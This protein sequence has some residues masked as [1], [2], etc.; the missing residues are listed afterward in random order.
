MLFEDDKE[1]FIL[2]KTVSKYIILYD[3]NSCVF[4]YPHEQEYLV[5]KIKDKE[6]YFEFDGTHIIEDNNDNIMK[7]LTQL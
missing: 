3:S 7:I 4:I 1:F 6:H 2:T 5:L